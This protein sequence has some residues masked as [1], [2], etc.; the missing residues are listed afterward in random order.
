V[1]DLMAH[2]GLHVNTVPLAWFVAIQLECVPLY[3][4]KVWPNHTHTHTH[5]HTHMTDCV[6]CTDKQY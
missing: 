6:M 4:N 1:Y 3:R 2:N 5:T